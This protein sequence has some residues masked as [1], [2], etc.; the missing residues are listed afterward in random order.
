MRKAQ[1]LSLN[2]IVVGALA[3]LVL[4]IIGGIIIF[5]GGDLLSGLTSIGASDE[6]VRITQFLSTCQSRCN[7]LNL[8]VD[9]SDLQAG[10]EDDYLDQLK[11]YCCEATDLD[12]S[13][14]YDVSGEFGPEICSLAFDCSLDGRLPADYCSD[15]FLSDDFYS[16]DDTDDPI[17][18]CGLD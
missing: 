3:L 8:L 11:S 18:E 10:D 2:L 14:T 9:Y 5:G 1:E 17:A 15:N 7:T 13:G 4:L 16:T 6:E 12:L